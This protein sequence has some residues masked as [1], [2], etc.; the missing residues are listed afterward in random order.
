MLPGKGDGPKAI[1]L[2]KPRCEWGEVIFITQARTA[3]GD[4][5]INCAAERERARAERGDEQR[6][7]HTNRIV[8]SA[9][10]NRVA[11]VDDRTRAD[12]CGKAEIVSS[13][14]G[15]RAHDGV[16]A[17]GSIGHAGISPEKSVAV[18]VCSILTG[19]ETEE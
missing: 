17:A 1:D 11:R 12:G 19:L 8:A 5:V 9:K 18:A 13:Q 16:I 6:A 2:F 14:V 7:R 10:D 15:V 3:G 4:L